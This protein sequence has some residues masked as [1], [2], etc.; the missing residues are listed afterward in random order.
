MDEGGPATLS[1]DAAPSRS[2]QLLEFT[3]R[4]MGNFSMRDNTRLLAATALLVCAASIGQAQQFSADV[5]YKTSAAAPA[6]PGGTA[7][8]APETRIF[9]SK[10]KL[11]L[12][13]RGMINMVMLVDTA[14]HSSYVLYPDQKA[15]QELGSRPSQYFAAADS[16]KACADWQTASGR[17]LKCEKVGA[18]AVDGRSAIKYRSIAADGGFEY[19]WIDSKLNYV[20]KWDLGQT[21]AELHNIKEAAQ[22]AQ[23][24]EIPQSYDVRK[25]AIKPPGHKAPHFS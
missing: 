7:A 17:Q 9:V 22:S 8:T 11:R 21:G 23:L 6:H 4:A 15:Y 20:I 1:I 13:S 5:V 2:Q 24:F 12:E 10:S 25:P 18:E 14:D 3:I 16:A 19:A